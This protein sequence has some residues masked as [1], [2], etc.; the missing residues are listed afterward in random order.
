[1]VDMIIVLGRV[2]TIFL[3][4]GG[5]ILIVVILF[6]FWGWLVFLVLLL[7]L[8]MASHPVLEMTPNVITRVNNLEIDQLS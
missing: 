6:V 8:A 1:M 2:I 3:A 4:K 5:D 7:I